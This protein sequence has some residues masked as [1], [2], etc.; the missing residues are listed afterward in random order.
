MKKMTI[1]DIAEMAGVSISTVSFVINNKGSVAESTRKKVLD[2]MNEYDYQYQ[3][4]SKNRSNNKNIT[5]GVIITNQHF[6]VDEQFYITIYHSVLIEAE[7]LKKNIKLYIINE[8]EARNN[9]IPDTLKSTLTDNLQ[10][11]IILGDVFDHCYKFIQEL[12]VPKVV[13]NDYP[14]NLEG[15]ISIVPDNFNGVYQAVSHLIALGHRKIG[16]I[17]PMS[18]HFSIK[19]RLQ[20]YKETLKKHNIEPDEKKIFLSKVIDP[21]QYGYACGKRIVD[22]GIDITALYVVCDM[23]AIGCIKALQEEDIK[24]PNDISIV[25]NDDIILSSYISPTLTTVRTSRSRLGEIGVQ[26]II[27]MIDNNRVINEKYVVPVKLIIRDSCGGLK[28]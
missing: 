5:I 21:Y 15:I 18:D 17:G 24:I 11:I 4:S 8:D 7:R 12:P 14:T 23:A 25:G 28:R 22:E 16:F 3:P 6:F 2:L 10:G 26:K 19:E 20:G 27:S 1:K 9:M 13:I